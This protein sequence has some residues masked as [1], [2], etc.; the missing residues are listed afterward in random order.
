M[1]DKFFLGFIRSVASPALMVLWTVASLE[2]VF[3]QIPSF[4]KSFAFWTLELSVTHVYLHI[5]TISMFVVCEIFIADRTLVLG[6]SEP[7]HWVIDYD[8]NYTC[9]KKYENLSGA[10]GMQNGST[11]KKWWLLSD[12]LFQ[13]IIWHNKKWGFRHC[14]TYCYKKCNYCKQVILNMF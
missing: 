10:Y 14:I 8:W 6:Q 9:I 7:D 11:S 13:W 1:R 12:I 2:V 4:E 5:M 3:H